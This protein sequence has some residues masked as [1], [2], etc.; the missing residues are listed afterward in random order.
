MAEQLIRKFG[1]E[2]WKDLKESVKIGLLE[3]S[4]QLGISGIFRFKKTIKFLKQGDYEKAYHE[5]LDSTWAKQ[6]PNRALKVVR[7]FLV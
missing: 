2:D 1:D 7:N 3:M 4:Y 6:T 5:A